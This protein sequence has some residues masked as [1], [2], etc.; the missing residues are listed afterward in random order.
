ML[1]ILLFLQETSVVER[2]PPPFYRKALGNENPESPRYAG[3]EDPF[4]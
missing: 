1:V 3:K 4:P 2:I